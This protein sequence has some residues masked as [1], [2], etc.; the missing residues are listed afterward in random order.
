MVNFFASAATLLTIAIA[1]LA[2]SQRSVESPGTIP[3]VVPAP[4]G[5]NITSLEVNGS[6]IDI[7]PPHPFSQ[8]HY[9]FLLFR[10]EQGMVSILTA[11]YQEMPGNCIMQVDNE[12]DL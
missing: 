7:L 9:R 12:I 1:D 10:C 5:F 6:G 2:T 8:P 11:S 4:V 3:V